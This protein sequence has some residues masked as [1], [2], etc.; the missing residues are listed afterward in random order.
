M[1]IYRSAKTLA[2]KIESLKRRRKTIGFVPTMGCLHEGHL[3]LMRRAR[4][5]TD[6]VIVSIFVNPIQ[7]GPKEDFKRYPRDLNRDLEL[8]EKEKVNIVFIPQASAMY[9]NGFSAYVN[10]ENLTNGLCGSLRPGHFKGVATVVTKL[11]NIVRPDVA[12]FGQKDAQQAIVIKKM[13]EDLNMPIKIRTM[14]IV[15]EKDGLAMS[16]RNL[17]LSAEERRQALSL[18]RSLNVAKALRKKG[19]R[20]PKKIAN[21]MRKVITAEKNPKIDYISIVDLENLKDV[22]RI[23]RKALVA[24]AVR[25]GKIRLIDNAIL[26]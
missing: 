11:F 12:Y 14:P 9:R 13:V 26:R 19:E 15:R 1:E 20:N 6:C 16:S 4:K 5:D 2:V 10:V 21:R 8:C 7:F 24:L 25:I 22:D 23:P 17:Y 18:Y 3:S